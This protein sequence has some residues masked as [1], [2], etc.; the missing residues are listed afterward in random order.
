MLFCF[1]RAEVLFTFIIFLFILAALDCDVGWVFE[2]VSGHCYQG[3]DAVVEQWS[4]ARAQC[5]L[6]GADLASITSTTELEFIAGKELRLLDPFRIY[7][8]LEIYCLVDT[9]N[10][11]ILSSAF[12]A[13]SIRVDEENVLFETVQSTHPQT[14]RQ[15]DLT[16][17]S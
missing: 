11:I 14:F 5:V 2:P 16:F 1:N 15:K 9:R 13:S 3:F 6:H 10:H 8:S 17:F 4:D 12:I 7:I